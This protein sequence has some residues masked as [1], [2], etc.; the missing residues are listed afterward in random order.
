MSENTW[1]HICKYMP[2][3]VV[4]MWRIETCLAILRRRRGESLQCD[5]IKE[6]LDYPHLELCREAVERNKL[7]WLESRNL[8][9]G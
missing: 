3:V 2:E 9:L 8:V 6:G 5:E 7:F 1:R 4:G